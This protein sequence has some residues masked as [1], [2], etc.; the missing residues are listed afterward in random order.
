MVFPKLTKALKQGLSHHLPL[1][2]LLFSLL[3]FTTI[4]SLLVWQKLNPQ[5]GDLVAQ[6]QEQLPTFS[7]CA[8]LAQGIKDAAK[9]QN[10]YDQG[11]L[12]I[13]PTVQKT[14]TETGTSQPEFST[15][16]IQVEGVDEA[17]IVKSD[18]TYF[19]IVK[20]NEVLI[21]RAYPPTDAKVLSRISIKDGTPKEI[22][23]NDDVLVVIGYKSAAIEEKGST[24]QEYWYG[25]NNLSFVD[26]YDTNDKGKPILARSLEF[27]G[28]YDTSRMIGNYAYLVLGT[29]RY[30]YNN[31]GEV[32]GNENLIPQYR[33]SGTDEFT[34]ICNCAQIKKFDPIESSTFLTI[35]AVP[36]KD[37]EAKV[38]AETILGAG[39]NLYASLDNL[40]VANTSY[41]S[42]IPTILNK[43]LDYLKPETEKTYI[44]KFNLNQGKINYQGMGAVPGYVLNQFSMD[45][46]QGNF[47]IA[48]TVGQIARGGGNASNNIYIL[49]K[50]L[51]LTG[52]IEGI[53]PGEKIYAARFMGKKGYLVTFKKVDP[54]FTL[55]LSDPQNPKIAGQLKI[56]GYSDY[57]HPLDEN[58]ILGIGKNSIEA[59]KGGFAWYQGVKMAIFDVTDFENPKE[60]FKTEIG[61]RGTDSFVLNDHKAFLYDSKKQLLVIPILLAELTASQR[62]NNLEANTYG[63]Y[64][65][66][67]AYVYRL[68]LEDGFK[69]MGR[70]TH[71]DDFGKDDGYYYYGDDK[72]ILRSL[73]IDN[74]LYTLSQT[75]LKVNLLDNLQ[76]VKTITL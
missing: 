14:T 5:G 2:I 47:R 37:F 30:A 17:D 42:E 6:N 38:N 52:K 25:G 73:F 51:D 50:N 67:G 10:Y 16:N 44:Y 18:G 39:D 54:F 22:F 43:I 19:Y 40:Y 28:S 69:L 26:L 56:P 72:A 57:L 33:E 46:Y 59:E 35:A 60:M 68:N 41:S 9:N 34:P 49:D 48:T 70:I 64:T 53:A 20:E 31:T 32:E 12:N 27:E 3:V 76:E 1:S 63:E 8:E 13:L 66:Q 24:D 74:Y 45:E 75:T 36:L 71:Y 7:S 4:A 15:T 11:I 62:E 65:F 29:Y 21:A 23:I 55:D 61:D 58:H